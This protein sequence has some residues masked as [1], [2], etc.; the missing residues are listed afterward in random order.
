MSTATKPAARTVSTIPTRW[1][2]IRTRPRSTAGRS[3]ATDTAAAPATKAGPRGA[4]AQAAA[5]LATD[6]T[7]GRPG[8]AWPVFAARRRRTM[9]RRWRVAPPKKRTQATKA[10][11]AGTPRPPVAARIAAG[12][13]RLATPTPASSTGR[14]RAWLRVPAATTAPPSTA[15]GAATTAS[16]ER[17]TEVKSTAPPAASAPP[18]PTTARRS[19][20][21]VRLGRLWP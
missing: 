18:A 11:I 8:A 6:Q 10:A 17:G 21:R 19:R 5:T 16:A 2:R 1:G 12:A 9:A 4:R 13:A 3:A 15:P 20:A 7:Q 14:A